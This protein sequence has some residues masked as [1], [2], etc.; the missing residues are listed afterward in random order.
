ME[1]QAKDNLRRRARSVA[2]SHMSKEFIPYNTPWWQP[3]TWA[4]LLWIWSWEDLLEHPLWTRNL[5]RRCGLVLFDRF[6]FPKIGVE[7]TRVF[8]YNGKWYCETTFE[9]RVCESIEPLK[10]APYISKNEW[11]TGWEGPWLDVN[12]VRKILE[13]EERDR[14]ALF[15]SFLPG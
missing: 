6:S 5:W 1:H 2:R 15:G 9:A 13:E 14:R 8:K 3:Y 4:I 10:A 7:K 11:G 12:L